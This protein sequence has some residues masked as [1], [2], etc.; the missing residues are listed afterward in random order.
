MINA[1][2]RERPAAVAPQT[3][4]GGGPHNTPT[5]VIDST[6]VPWLFWVRVAGPNRF[7]SFIRRVD[8]I[9]TAPQDA[10]QIT[11]LLN[12]NSTAAVACPR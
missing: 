12:V 5:A 8:G 4:L 9:W 6:G 3:I 2:L 1:I 10:F 7:M 11:G